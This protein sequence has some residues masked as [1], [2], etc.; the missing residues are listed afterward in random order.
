[1]S[2]FL[3]LLEGE[4]DIILHWPFKFQMRISL[5]NQEQPIED[6]VEVFEPGRHPTC[7][8]E[9]TREVTLGPGSPKFIDLRILQKGGFIKDDCLFMKVKVNEAI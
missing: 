5:F 3:A 2:L 1:M 9:P 7:F 6:L 4:F 8:Q